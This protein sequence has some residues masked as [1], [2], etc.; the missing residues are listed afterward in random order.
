MTSQDTSYLC[1][2]L[3]NR[4]SEFL[5]FLEVDLKRRGNCFI[6]KCPVHDGSNSRGCVIYLR[7]SKVDCVWKCLTQGCSGRDKFG[8]SIFGFIRG[9][10]LNHRDERISYYDAIQIVKTFLGVESL[11]GLINNRKYQALKYIESEP[12]KSNC[13]L[14]LTREQIRKKLQIPCPFFMKRGISAEI[15][16]KYDVGYIPYD[17]R[18]EK[19]LT[20]RS[21]IPIYDGN[22]TKVIGCQARSNISNCTELGIPKWRT[23]KGFAVNH[24]LYNLWFAKETI[25]QKNTA[26]LVESATNCW[27]L[28]QNGITNVLCTFGTNITDPQR[29]QLETL[30]F[31]NLIVIFDNDKE[32]AGFKGASTI[33]RTFKKLYR[34]RIIDI[35]KFEKNDLADMTDLEI[36]T[37][38][39]ENNL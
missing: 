9:V 37:L 4:L 12:P 16:D 39:Q 33:A 38:K 28:L 26:I 15:L 34:V 32:K 6:G 31:G 19:Y 35:G 30:F 18:P 1:H 13:Q 11:D 21:V 23:L 5:E 3:S 27:K 22:Y 36:Q 25:I 7:G 10:Y 14:N 8:Q 17:P 29:Q 2:L 24:H 20:N